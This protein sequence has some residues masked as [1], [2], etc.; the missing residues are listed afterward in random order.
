VNDSR[1]DDRLNVALVMR[2]REPTMLE[3]REGQCQNV[4]LSGMCIVTPKPSPRG[5][6]IRFECI[7]GGAADGIRG[8]AR[9]VWQR[10]KSDKRGAACMG[11]RFVRLEPGCREA[12]EALVDQ[13]GGERKPSGPDVPRA[14]AA[15][16]PPHGN[17]GS[18][19]PGQATVI[20]SPATG[21]GVT[22]QGMGAARGKSVHYPTLRGIG[23]D[24][25]VP[26]RADARGSKRPSALNV[27]LPG[28]ATNPATPFPT[29]PSAP[30][31]PPDPSA[32]TGKLRD[33][34]DRTRR[35]MPPAS[36][37]VPDTE[38]ESAPSSDRPPQHAE[39]LVGSGAS[40]DRPQHDATSDRP[41]QPGGVDDLRSS[42][43]QPPHSPHPSSR[44]AAA[45]PSGLAMAE[46]DDAAWA[47]R[48]A[49]AAAVPF[50]P[51]DLPD[52][53]AARKRNWLPWVV[54]GGGLLA[55][56]VMIRAFGSM[57]AGVPVTTNLEEPAEA[58][59]DAPAEPAAP[60]PTAPIATVGAAAGLRTGGYVLEVASEPTGA[61]IS[62]AD[63][64]ML[65]PAVIELAPVTAPVLVQAELEGY[66]TTSVTVDPAAFTL[67]DGRRVGKT[68]VKL[69]PVTDERGATARDT[70]DRVEHTARST[71]P[72]KPR[73][74]VSD[75]RS[76][77]PA[78]P[79]IA[80]PP[81]P[82]DPPA[83]AS[84]ATS[85][86]PASASAAPA[87]ESSPAPGERSALERALECLSRGDNLCVISTLEGKAKTARELEV[88]IET[89]LALGNAVDAERSMR[90]YLERH[91]DSKTA[92]K[93]QR[94][95][96][97]RG[98]NETP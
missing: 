35:G 84:E 77:P 54:I 58:P 8:T 6:L 36:T 40:S 98:E 65:A 50:D 41:P 60:A 47:R 49:A 3:P 62:A 66:E 64:V 59:Q 87:V 76:Q 4:S 42:S 70:S 23:L 92:P 5:A 61:R 30:P 71:A 39:T 82:I 57:P 16:D 24:S 37:S 78:T 12:L 11:V 63:Q 19:R 18:D 88:L 79:Q 94:W 33:R 27:T 29:T 67:Q 81:V 10:G 1:K 97:R 80:A 44:P 96:E 95:L 93:Y 15:S 21:S 48:R 89:H 31:E 25:S 75:P 7:S 91:A 9:V 72:R 14:P 2:Y 56:W 52:L 85:Q 68:V 17:P 26:P 74:R 53:D 73:V 22:Q 90:R 38:S 43:Q 86:P 51:P 13:L 83:P 46:P 55:S 28:H 20:I 34:V 32:A 45:E 69:T